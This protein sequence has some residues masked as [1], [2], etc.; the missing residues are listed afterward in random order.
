MMAELAKH[1]ALIRSNCEETPFLPSHVSLPAAELPDGTLWYCVN[2]EFHREDGPAIINPDGT[3]RWYR[4]G[5]LHRDGGPAMTDKKTGEMRWY[6]EDALHREDGPAWVDSK[7]ESHYFL[8]GESFGP[9]AYQ[10][11]LT[12]RQKSNTD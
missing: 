5:K 2:G 8:E 10:R 3:E 12:K 11:E 7:G 9:Q 4:Y 6:Q 1:G